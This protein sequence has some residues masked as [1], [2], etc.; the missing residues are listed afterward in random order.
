MPIVDKYNVL[1]ESGFYWA[2]SGDYK[3]FN[4]IVHI[5]GEVP[6]LEWTVWDMGLNERLLKGKGKPDFVFGLK[7]EEPN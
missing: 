1:K 3:W 7:I 6:Y 4:C 2:K 5:H